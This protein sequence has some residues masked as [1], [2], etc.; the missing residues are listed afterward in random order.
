ME[1]SINHIETTF[2]SEQ[3]ERKIDYNVIKLYDKDLL[4]FGDMTWGNEVSK[5]DICVSK[6]T[7]SEY[8]YKK[9]GN[10]E[11]TDKGIELRIAGKGIF[12]VVPKDDETCCIYE[13]ITLN[14]LEKLSIDAIKNQPSLLQSF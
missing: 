9:V 14:S 12:F 8:Q 2:Y 4:L 7:N 13:A 1:L 10:W 5:G 3:N 6:I 11:N